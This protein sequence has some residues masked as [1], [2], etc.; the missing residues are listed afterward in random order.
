MKTLKRLI[1]LAVLLSLVAGG[2][3]ARGGQESGKKTLAFC[4]PAMISPYYQSVIK[5]AQE[6]ADKLGYNLITLAPDSE[7]N[8]AAQVQIVEDQ[9]TKKVDG[10]ILC[11]INTD[12]I[13]SAVRKANQANIP[14]VMFNTQNELT[15]GAQVACYVRYDQREAGRKVAD[16]VG[17]TFNGTANVAIILGLPSDHT[18]ERR[19][20]FLELAQSKYPNIKLVAEQPGDWEREKGMNAAAN[21]LTAN[22]EITVFFGLSDEMAL[23]AYQAVAR[24][25]ATNRVAVCGFD[26]TPASVASVRAGQL[27]STISIGGEGTGYSCV[28]ALDKIIK[29]QPVDKFITVDTEMVTKA[30]AMNFVAE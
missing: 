16:F 11:A 9:I 26:G 19:G 17:Q 27:L 20:G 13:V 3:F 15:G 28:E 21:M 10:I 24:A 8:Y 2:L 14:V 25:N 23:G 6:A 4:P 1:I 5:G 7:S 30:N 18:T 12:A 29:K 22:P